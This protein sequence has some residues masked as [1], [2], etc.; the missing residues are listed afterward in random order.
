MKNILITE[1]C[2]VKGQ[3]TPAG[4]KLENVDNTLAAELLASGRAAL[5]PA[6][7]RVIVVPDPEVETRDP[8]PAK[9]GTKP[10]PKPAATEPAATEA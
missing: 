4:T 3:H 8:E 10:K 7:K 5:P 1:D 9:K 2:L 6:D